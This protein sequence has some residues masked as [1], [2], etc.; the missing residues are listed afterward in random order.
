MRWSPRTP[1]SPEYRGD[2]ATSQAGS[3]ACSS[4]PAARRGA[5]RA[6]VGPGP[7]R[8]PGPASPN[9]P[10]YRDRLAG[11]LNPPATP[12]RPGPARRGPRP[13]RPGRRPRRGA[14]LGGS[15]DGGYRSRLANGLRRLAPASW[16]PGTQPGPRPTPA[17]PSNS[18]RGCPPAGRGVVRPGLRPGDALGRRRPRRPG[19]LG[20]RGSGL[21]DRAMDDLRR[22]AAM[23]YRDVAQYRREPRRPAPGPR[24]LPGAAARRGL[25][26]R[27]VREVNP[28]NHGEAGLPAFP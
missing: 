8:G 15:E 13:P 5:A 26:G 14:G 18:S 10:E 16:P 11:T 22:A 6:G 2:L 3:A 9:V 17:G 21:A 7:P 25:P 23:G 20:R 27:P 1:P 28:R 12:S 24:R 4:R 19:A